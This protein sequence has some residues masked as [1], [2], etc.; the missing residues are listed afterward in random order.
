[1]GHTV[2]I[3]R[4]WAERSDCDHLLVSLPY[5]WSPEFEVC[6]WEQGHIRVLWQLPVTAAEKAFRHEHGLEALE[7]R[8]VDHLDQSDD[9]LV[10]LVT[11]SMD[12]RVRPGSAVIS[13]VG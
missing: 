11:W 9:V 2:P 6:D 10:E 7:Q 12:S 4:P 1:M 13:S 8:L 3:G 5:P